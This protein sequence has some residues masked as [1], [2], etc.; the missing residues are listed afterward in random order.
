MSVNNPLLNIWPE[1]IVICMISLCKTYHSPIFFF[2]CRFLI[3]KVWTSS[4]Q[5]KIHPVL[6]YCMSFPIIPN[7]NILDCHISYVNCGPKT[8]TAKWSKIPHLPSQ[9]DRRSI[10][11][12]KWQKDL[13][14]PGTGKCFNRKQ[15]LKKVLPGHLLGFQ[16][17]I[18]SI[19]KQSSREQE[20]FFYGQEF[21]FSRT[22][23]HVLF[24]YAQQFSQHSKFWFLNGTWNLIW[25]Q[26][27]QRY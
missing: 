26:W 14:H 5:I 16:Y 21:K 23:T 8:Q 4:L 24:R 6:C 22:W 12:W 17:C 18:C 27:L 15:R 3:N 11:W 1:A 10:I 2:H 20:G 25:C 19:H 7:I 9:Y 13:N